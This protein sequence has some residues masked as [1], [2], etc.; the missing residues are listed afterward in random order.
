MN[1]VAGG[2]DFLTADSNA[3][4]LSDPT[5]LQ[6]LELGDLKLL[7]RTKTGGVNILDPA[8]RQIK[9]YGLK[10]GIISDY[11]NGA[12]EASDSTLWISTPN[13]LSHL[14]RNTG[15]IQNYFIR[16]VAGAGLQAIRRMLGGRIACKQAPTL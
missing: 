13:G 11:I 6:I 7:L 15:S 4:K 8:T 12:M 9:I 10:E 5:V 14:D 2:F 16:E 3:I 1:L